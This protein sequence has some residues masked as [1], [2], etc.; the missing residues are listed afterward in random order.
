[1]L[2]R[3]IILVEQFREAVGTRLLEIP[4]GTLEG[5]ESPEECARRELVEET[6]YEPRSLRWIYSFFPSPGT[7]DEQIH[8][9]FADSV[10]RI[11]EP[12]E[13]IK[14]VVMEVGD[15]LRLVRNGAIRDGKTVIGVLMALPYI[16]PEKWPAPLEPR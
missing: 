15:V 16:D 4:A 13:G 14:V 10:R 11:G 3:G 8:I 1:M 6:G 12:E 5:G 9:Y 2:G 7:S